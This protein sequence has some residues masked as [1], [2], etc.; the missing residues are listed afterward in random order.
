MPKL[1]LNTMRRYKDLLQRRE[2]GR[3]LRRPLPARRPL[4]KFRKNWPF[5]QKKPLSG[6]PAKQNSRALRES[7]CSLPAI[8]AL[9]LLAGPGIMVEAFFERG[10]GRAKG[11][12]E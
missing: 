10:K 11:G 12:W 8:A 1:T 2:K 5:S 3:H 7:R 6:A 9:I 4:W